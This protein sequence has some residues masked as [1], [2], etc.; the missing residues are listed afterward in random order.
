MKRVLLLMLAAAAVPQVAQAETWKNV[1]LI[2]TMCVA[3]AEVNADPDSHP[4][5][6]AIQCQG[7]GYGI[8]AADGSFL[9]FDSVGN[10]KA[11]AALKTTKKADHLRVEVQG[12][13]RGNEIQVKS[14]LFD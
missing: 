8:L 9:K 10:A 3:K 12:E 4:T 14:V 5:K 2:D 1:P 13:R 6:C 7:S 11:T